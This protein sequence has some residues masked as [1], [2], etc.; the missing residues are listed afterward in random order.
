MDLTYYMHL[1][2]IKRRNWLQECTECKASKQTKN[3]SIKQWSCVDRM[4]VPLCY[5]RAIIAL[6][7]EDIAIQYNAK[8]HTITCICRL[9]RFCES[10]RMTTKFP[11][12]SPLLYHVSN[13]LKPISVNKQFSALLFEFVCVFRRL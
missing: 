2:G 3:Q 10:Y 12:I 11:N 13:E 1:V 6:L 7:T 8:H 9:P 5:L 4:R